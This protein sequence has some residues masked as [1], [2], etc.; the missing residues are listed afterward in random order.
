MNDSTHDVTPVNSQATSYPDPEGDPLLQVAIPFLSCGDL[1][2]WDA[3]RS[4]D[5]PEG[6][7]TSL[8]PV[9]LPTAPPYK[10]ALEAL[11]AASGQPQA[12]ATPREE[13]EAPHVQH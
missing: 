2:G 7:Y 4:Y 11:R 6:G 5:L 1:H 13:R 9:Q 3:D 10:R 8:P 12:E